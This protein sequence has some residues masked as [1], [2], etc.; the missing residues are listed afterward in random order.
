LN[1]RIDYGIT[2]STS[3]FNPYARAKSG[4]DDGCYFDGID[5]FY[6]YV[7]GSKGQDDEKYRVA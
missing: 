7:H 4:A 6:H 1:E 3:G 2:Q 5:V